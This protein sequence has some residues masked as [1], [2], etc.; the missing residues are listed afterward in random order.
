M[1][2]EIT[3]TVDTENPID[4]SN[5][6]QVILFNKN[7]KVHYAVSRDS[8]LAEQNAKIKE[9]E[10]KLNEATKKLVE[11]EKAFEENSNKKFNEF[12]KTYKESNAIMINMIK[13]LTLSDKEAV[14]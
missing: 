5:N 10:T 2:Q 13:Q 7:K 4:L 9:L 14:K 8:L 1:L 12:L 6:A 11:Q 3:L